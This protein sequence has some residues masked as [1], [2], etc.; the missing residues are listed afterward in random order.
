MNIVIALTI[1][2]LLFGVA[3]MPRKDTK[4]G[5]KASWIF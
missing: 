3:T 2:G 1:V 5:E 4:K